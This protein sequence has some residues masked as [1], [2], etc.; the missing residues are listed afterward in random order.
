[1]GKA[2]SHRS[3][4]HLSAPRFQRKLFRPGIA[5]SAHEVKASLITLRAIAPSEDE[6][7]ASLITVGAIQC[8]VGQKL[9]INRLLGVGSEP[10]I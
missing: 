2:L 7:R 1:M 5:P 4:G 10:P 8:P 3:T 9:C 6:A